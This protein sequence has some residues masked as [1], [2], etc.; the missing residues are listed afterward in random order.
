MSSKEGSKPSATVST[1]KKGGKKSEYQDKEKPAAIRMSNVSAAKGMPIF[2][3]ISL[4]QTFKTA[5][6]IN[7]YLHLP[8]GSSFYHVNSQ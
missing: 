4:Q 3:A 5:S 1:A 6:V 2:I 7:K 8:C